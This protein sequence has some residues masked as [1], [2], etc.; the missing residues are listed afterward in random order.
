MSWKFPWSEFVKKRACRY[1]LQHYLGHFLK[2]K[3]TL[4]QLSVDLYN[5]TGKIRQLDL[6]VEAINEVLDNS[7][8]PVEI[9]D[10]FIDEIAVSIPWTALIQ[11]STEMEIRGLELTLQ[12]KQRSSNAQGLETMFCS[13][14][15]SMTTSLQIAEE[16]LKEDRAKPFRG[17]EGSLGDDGGQQFEGV[18]KFAQTIDSVLCRVKVTLVDT[19]IRLEH[20]PNSAETGVALEIRIK[21]ME[22]FDDMAEGSSVDNTEFA[23]NWEPAAVAHKNFLME[24]MH[25]L[26]DH[27]S[28][29]SRPHSNH[30]DSSCS[31]PQNYDS[32]TSSPLGPPRNINQSS[33]CSES[34]D[35]NE[36]IQVAVVTGKTSLKLKIKQA[37]SVTGPKL[38]TE[39]E[40]GALH[41][42]LAP[43]Q[44]HSL[45]EIME[46]LISP[47]TNEAAKRRHQSNRNKPMSDEDM[48]RIERELQRQMME[49]RVQTHKKSSLDS[50]PLMG[51]HDIM[52]SSMVSS[53]SSFTDEE[54]CYYS[55]NPAGKSIDME[56]SVSSN[57]SL[58]SNRTS[59]TVTSR[60]PSR[61]PRREPS[62]YKSKDTLQRILDDPSAEM[63]RYHLRL[64]FFTVS[65]LHENPRPVLGDNNEQSSQKNKMKVISDAFFKRVFTFHPAGKSELKEV[66]KH[67]AEALHRDHLRFVGKP[68]N[69]ECIEKTVPTHYSTTVDLTI[70]L[71]EAVECLFDRRNESMKPEYTELLVF[72]RDVAPSPTHSSQMYSSMHGGAPCVK[73]TIK[74][75]E[76]LRGS[77]K[78]NSF[79]RTEISFV[80]AQL[81]SEV[82]ITIVDRI[83]SLIKPE[84]TRRPY[85]TSVATNMTGGMTSYALSQALDDGPGTQEHKYDLQISCPAAKLS[86]RF[87]IPDLRPLSQVDKL[88]W[89]QKNL[90]DE[91]LIL[92]MSDVL[93]QTS[94]LSSQTISELEITCRDIHAF[95]KIDPIKEEPEPFAF[96]GG[97]ENEDGCNNFPRL[98]IKFSNKTTSVLEEEPVESEDNTPQDSLHGACLFTKRDP[99]PFSNKKNMYGKE[100]YSEKDQSTHVSEEMI[101]P[102]D[103]REIQEF[104]EKSLGNTHMTLEFSLPFV[105][106]YIPDK[107]F[108]EVL[109]N[110][111]NS[112][113]LLWEPMAPSPLQTQDPLLA[114]PFDLSCYPNALQD[115]FH[116]A[117]SAIKYESSDEED[118]TSF[119]YYSIHD[120][121]YPRRKPTKKEQPSKLCL[122]LKIDKG[123]LT[124]IT[125]SQV[126]KTHGEVV[127]LLED[128]NIFTVAN[129]NGDPSLQYVCFFSH[130]AELYHC[131]NVDDALKDKTVNLTREDICRV[132][133]H[134]RDHRLVHKTDPG[135]MAKSMEMSYDMDT[136][137]MVSVAVKIKL[138]STPINDLTKDEKIKEFLVAVGIRGGTLRHKMAAADQSWISQVLA[139]L[140]VKD[141]DILGY[142]MAK[143]LTELHV[144]L[145]DCAVD[146]RPLH[147][148]TNA[149]LM[150]ES[151]SISSNII[152]ESPTS[153]LRFVLD[154][155]SLFL[156]QK[157][158]NTMPNLRKDYVCVADLERF[159]LSLRFSDGKDLKFPK[160]DLKVL[161]NRLNL[162]TCSDSCKALMEL[163]QY[164]ANDGDLYFHEETP[165]L[166][167]STQD[168]VVGDEL[169]DSAT[170]DGDAVGLTVSRQGHLETLVEDAM[171]ESQQAANLPENASPSSTTEVYFVTNGG[172]TSQPVPPAGGIRPIVISDS[173]D[174][175]A[176][177]ALSE[178]MEVMSDDEEFCVIDDP[179]LGIMPRDGEP[180]IRVLVT[181]P[182]EI[183]ENFFSQPLGRTDLLKSPDHYPLAEQRYTLKEMTLVWYI[184][185]GSDFKP[186]NVDNTQGKE[187]VYSTRS[188]EHGDG[189]PI[190]GM[191][192]TTKASTET[193]NRSPWQSR[194]GPGRDTTTLMELQLT[195]VQMQHE[196]YPS[197]TE[198]ASRQILLINDLELRDRLESSNINKFLYRYSSE[199]MPRQ[200]N[201]NMLL[202]KAI[203]TRPDPTVRAEECALRVS[204]QPLR[205]N[206]DQDS[207]AFLKIFFTEVSGGGHTN[208]NPSP[209]ESD[210][211][212]RTRSTPGTNA[213]SPPPPVMV[214]G[215]PEII[216][217]ETDPQELLMRFDEL[218]EEQLGGEITANDP[219]PDYDNTPTQAVEKT[220]YQPVFFKSFIFSPDVPIRLDYTGK[221]RVDR[222]HGALTGLLAGLA[223]LNCSELKLKG[224]NHQ[225]GLLGFDR[226]LQYTA[227]EWLTDIRKNQLPSILGGVGPMHSF[228][229]L[230]Q[231]MKDLF[232]LPVEQYR[233]DGRIVRGIQRGASSFTTSTAMAVLELTNRVVQSVQYVAEVT[234]DMVSPG[235]S[236]RTKGLR[237][238]KKYGRSGQP[239]DLR[240]GMTNAYIVLKEGFSDTA[241]NMVIVASK[242]HEQKGVTGA[243]GGVIR[244]IPPTVIS[245]LIIA[246]EATSN[247]LGGMRNQIKP[248]ARKEDE[249]KW[250]S[251]FIS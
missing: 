10:G 91:I 242:E 111:V 127:V 26:I 189:S 66:R 35:Q 201:A 166:R 185:G 96:V 33:E 119:G 181:D 28:R 103:R 53:Y 208:P 85:S 126:E 60:Q 232:W 167:D 99:S 49:G 192:Y 226:L 187:A 5:G 74:S 180:S 4:E 46:G 211:K 97:D 204:V 190:L 143:V 149:V 6:D 139:F 224:I 152:A 32:A 69:L 233:K 17:R 109:Y 231:G 57:F 31:S 1:L 203:H 133:D 100:E 153:L 243:M 240:E 199:S 70:G 222:E 107:H 237:R 84:P 45:L 171:L 64:T 248:D 234:F 138:D 42:L 76:Q 147:I 161:T 229:Q 87:P 219:V 8:L 80:L 140:D 155:A 175:F 165:S 79:P 214:V 221:K 172:G 23:K 73:A 183:K 150:A 125:N 135:V 196:K 50:R 129:H 81:E 122:S 89:W 132:A 52:T 157:P 184:Y 43:R 38:E 228:V 51:M 104:Q 7:N 30:S 191:R 178:R 93:F 241:Q 213:P 24:G 3:L 116:M 136:N 98:S 11:S 25:I 95:F 115:S 146:Y 141:Y 61:A 236:V 123:K 112:D 15:S 88:P 209:P 162:R 71:F 193:V 218:Q 198:Q 106:L 188:K 130:K 160:T 134:L 227:N 105:D 142:T 110:R 223:Q 186:C 244:Q 20:L 90:R 154:D 131:A 47:G 59:S 145:W 120:S 48:Q 37:D 230:A 179:G 62:H 63:C 44:V 220:P 163:I 195:K 83:N 34:P 113:L 65:I 202:V 151:F 9:V 102:G 216:E 56:S 247:V 108:Y 159:E 205:L 118:D 16:C 68:L 249:E 13:M 251:E 164:F 22:Y 77:Q 148:K 27:F 215:H 206:V 177:S 18:Q 239:A 246:S 217:E 212:P 194:G 75:L 235:P 78:A 176:S 144:H 245:P 54:D 41:I 238:R 174:S 94:Y 29:N 173:A 128:A 121:R 168:L 2:E 82:D 158:V 39:V 200:S 40:L 156:S 170:E 14:N 210:T 250:K 58:T 86:L 101:M 72:H 169:Q 225:H 36:P 67:F 137:D 114:A 92:Q 55:L 207:L 19:V 124:A 12:P 182:I 197:N 21:R 117:K